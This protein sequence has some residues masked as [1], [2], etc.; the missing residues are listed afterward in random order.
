MFVLNGRFRRKHT[1]PRLGFSQARNMWRDKSV[2]YY[3][4]NFERRGR[5]AKYRERGLDLE[6]LLKADFLKT[7]ILFPYY[8]IDIAEGFLFPTGYLGAVILINVLKNIFLLNSNRKSF[9]T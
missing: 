1:K 9:G 4:P 3:Q 8:K 7:Y 5:G 6:I 2:Y